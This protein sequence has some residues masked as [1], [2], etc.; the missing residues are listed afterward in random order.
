MAAFLTFLLLLGGGDRMVLKETASADGRYVRLL[1]VVEP[2][3]LG[4]EAREILGGVWLGRAPGD[5]AERVI[6]VEEI[7][8]ELERR[9]IRVSRFTFVGDA[10]TVRRGQEGAALAARALRSLICVELKGQF[11]GDVRA[12][13]RMRYSVRVTYLSLGDVPEKAELVRVFPREPLR[14]GPVHFTATVA[15]GEEHFQVQGIARILR[16]VRVAFAQKSLRKYHIVRRE[17]IVMRELDLESEEGY[18]TDL[19]LLVGAK[20]LEKVHAGEPIPPGLV[21]FRAVIRRGDTVL[22][23]SGPVRAYGKALRDG[24]VGDYIRVQFERTKNIIACR[25]TGP[26]T[27]KHVEERK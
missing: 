6:T 2:G 18:C 9:G 13:D 16:V 14:I 21:K 23:I 27:A 25:V 3:A 12:A 1:D 19:G 20:L 11:L 4:A 24:S 5:G 7:Q 8:R 22:V 26:G 17:D 10:V 15:A